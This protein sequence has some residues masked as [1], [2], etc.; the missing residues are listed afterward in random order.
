ME[1]EAKRV[2]CYAMLCD[3]APHM[4]ASASAMAMPWHSRK[5]A[6]YVDSRASFCATKRGLSP[7]SATVARM[8]AHL[9]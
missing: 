4:F 1:V 6:R 7:S 3:A 2:L 8:A 5:L 9:A